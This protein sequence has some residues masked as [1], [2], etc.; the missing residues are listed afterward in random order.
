MS[1]GTLQLAP[2]I[3][4]YMAQYPDVHVE[5]ALNDR[6]VDPTEE[7]FDISISISAPR[8]VNSLITREICPARLLLCASSTYLA[9]NG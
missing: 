4:N 1:F 3:D 2:L 5:L 6:F 9:A 7:G 8:T